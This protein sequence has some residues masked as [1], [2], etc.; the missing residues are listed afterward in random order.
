VAALLVLLALAPV[1]TLGRYIGASLAVGPNNRELYRA[2]EIVAAVGTTK[3][4]LMDATLSGTR[5][6]TGREGT[7]VLE[8]LL[9][10]DS[11]VPVRRYQP[12]D[13]AVAVERGESD[14]VVV[15]PRLLARLDKDFVIEAPQG[16]AEARRQ[17]RA[18]FLVAR[19]V[20]QA[21][22]WPDSGLV[23]TDRSVP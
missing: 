8:Y 22:D 19:I 16:E 4:V 21:E 2:A 23:A 12:N 10:L 3:P 17:R 7:G 13:L 6:S 15:S 5:L 1:M 9:I 20:S 14:L 11:G 18:G